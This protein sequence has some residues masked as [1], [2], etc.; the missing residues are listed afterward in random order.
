MSEEEATPRDR[1]QELSGGFSIGQQAAVAT[2]GAVL[3]GALLA[4]IGLVLDLG[5]DQV[6][7]GLAALGLLVLIAVVY[8]FFRAMMVSA[9]ESDGDPLVALTY[10]LFPALYLFLAIAVGLFVGFYLDYV[11]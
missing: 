1:L 7:V 3:T 6:L 10:P 8:A 5:R 4:V 11:A 2:A 9:E